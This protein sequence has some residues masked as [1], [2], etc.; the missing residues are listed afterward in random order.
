[1]RDSSL[2]AAEKILQ[3]RFK[4]LVLLSIVERKSVYREETGC[5]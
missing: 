1:M 5:L 3:I 2:T 4:L